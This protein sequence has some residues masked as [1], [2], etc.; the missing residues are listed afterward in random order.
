MGSK[1]QIDRGAHERCPTFGTIKEAV[2]SER[3]PLPT[4]VE[5]DIDAGLSR[6]SRDTQSARS[7]AT[8]DMAAAE[9]EGRSTASGSDVGR[10]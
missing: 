3:E 10:V 8:D 2:W 5:R 6:R 1:E 9:R 7:A 4:F